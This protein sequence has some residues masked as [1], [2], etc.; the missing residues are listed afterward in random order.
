MKQGKRAP[1]RGKRHSVSVSL[2]ESGKVVGGTLGSQRD[3]G[4]RVQCMLKLQ[5]KASRT[6]TGI[7]RRDLLTAGGLSVLGLSLADLLQA[8]TGSSQPAGKARSVILIYLFGG[9]PKH[10]LFDPKPEAPA[11]IRGPFGTTATDLPG[12]HYSDLLPTMGRWLHRSSLVRSGTHVHNDHS[13]G[14]LYTMTGKKAKVLESAVPVL[15]TQAPSMNSVIQYLHRHERRALPA[16]IWMPC[17]AGWGQSSLRPGLYGGFLG[18]QFDPFIT[19]VEITNKRKA[20]DFYDSGIPEGVI[21]LPRTRLQPQVTLDR[22]D[23]RKSLLQQFEQQRSGFDRYRRLV[24]ADQF[25]VQAFELLTASNS[26]KSPWRAFQLD[27]ES[28][29]LRERYGRNLYGDG[30]LTSRRLVERG[31]RLVTMS[32]EAFETEGADPTAWDTH[33]NHFEIVKKHRAPVLDRAYSAL[34]EDLEQRGMLDETLIVI[35]GEMGRS[36][37]VNA[38]KGRDHWSYAYDV[39]FTGAGVKQGC[40][41]GASDKIGAYPADHPVGPADI[42]ATVYEAMGID[43]SGVIRDV[44]QRPQPIAQHG[45]PIAGILA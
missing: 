38:G 26:R 19:G 6:C 9:P 15:P 11:E 35:M 3:A 45:T 12:V 33:K 23:G 7:A 39:M 25:K 1:R 37:K 30:L 18:R 24:E 14:L 16:S 4:Q 28:P 13:A 34:C 21:R 20:K 43:S 10:E 29:R 42:V 31:V 27:E 5:A 41:F 36:P 40:V 32:W 8:E 2:P 44:G 17:Y 22:L